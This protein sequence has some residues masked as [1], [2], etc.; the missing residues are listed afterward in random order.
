M[1]RFATGVVVLTVKFP[2]IRKFLFI[3]HP[4]DICISDPGSFGNVKLTLRG[5]VVGVKTHT[6]DHRV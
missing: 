2:C 3:V 6:P 5:L 4:G 1:C